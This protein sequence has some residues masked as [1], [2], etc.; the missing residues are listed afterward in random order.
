MAHWS[1]AYIGIPHS[2]RGMS[3]EGVNCWTLVC[4][5]Y[6][7]Q[8]AISLPTYQEDFVSLDEYREVEAL[9]HGER[10][11]QTWQLVDQPEAFDVAVFRRGRHLTHVGIVVRQ[12]LMLHVTGGGAVALERYDS[13]Q[14]KPRLQHLYRHIGSMPALAAEA[15]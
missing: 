5:V 9:F 2:D 14:W 6:Q 15:A 4:L 12:G 3:R 13:G 11:R 1:N 7:E 10:V 8:L